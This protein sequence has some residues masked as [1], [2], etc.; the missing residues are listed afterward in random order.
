M[1][2][3]GSLIDSTELKKEFSNLDDRAIEIAQ[4]ET[5]REKK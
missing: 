1:P 3:K 4:T 5:L 2:S